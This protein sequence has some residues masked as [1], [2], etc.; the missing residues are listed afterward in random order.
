[1]TRCLLK[2]G[3]WNKLQVVH[4]VGTLIIRRLVVL[5]AGSIEG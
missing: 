3:I 5:V 4:W 2:L 1:M